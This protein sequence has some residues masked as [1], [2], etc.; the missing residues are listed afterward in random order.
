MAGGLKVAE[1]NWKTQ[2]EIEAEKNAPKEPTPEERLQALEL[3]M[4]DILSI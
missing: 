4:L 1:I 2:D 3:A